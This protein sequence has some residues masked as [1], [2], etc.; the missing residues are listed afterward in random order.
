MNLEWVGGRGREPYNLRLE[1]TEGLRKNHELGAPGF[2]R[3]TPDAADPQWIAMVI[4]ASL[5]SQAG[6]PS[7]LIP[8]FMMTTVTR[9]MMMMVM[10]M[11]RMRMLMLDEA[12]FREKA[13]YEVRGR[14]LVSRGGLFVFEKINK[15]EE[16]RR[17]K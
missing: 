9:L 13:G 17:H 11:M 1:G 2:S 7:L 3:L 8:F 12:F 10:R 5:A 16:R 4:V 15:R 6:V 14:P